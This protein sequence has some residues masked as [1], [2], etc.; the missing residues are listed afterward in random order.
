MSIL[1]DKKNSEIN[2]FS[3]SFTEQI[4]KPSIDRYLLLYWNSRFFMG[5]SSTTVFRV[6]S[7]D[8][9]CICWDTGVGRNPPYFLG[10]FSVSLL[11]IGAA[12]I[13]TVESSLYCTL[14]N[15]LPVSSSW[16]HG[17]SVWDKHSYQSLGLNWMACF[18]C[19]ASSRRFISVQLVSK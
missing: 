7:S 16:Q 15:S 10:W 2:P 4:L 6:T 17:G 1:I 18:S 8:N 14:A 12:D 5:Q 3:L 19:A 13:H 11:L 9:E